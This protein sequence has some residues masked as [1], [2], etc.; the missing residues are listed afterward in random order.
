MSRWTAAEH[1]S[2][3]EAVGVKGLKDHQLI[4]EFIGTKTKT[5]VADYSYKMIR[6]FKDNPEMEGAHLLAFLKM[7]KP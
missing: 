6:K 1:K 5:Q 7:K 2:W 3:K 4:A